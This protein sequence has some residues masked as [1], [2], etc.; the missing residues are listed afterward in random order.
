MKLTFPLFALAIYI[1]GFTA[2]ALA[3]ADQEMPLR[4]VS[5]KYGHEVGLALFALLFTAGLLGYSAGRESSR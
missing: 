2:Y 4:T 5:E 3:L 1:T